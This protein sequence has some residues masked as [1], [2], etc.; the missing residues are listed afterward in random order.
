VGAFLL[1]VNT[2]YSD[3]WSP[4]NYIDTG[5]YF[6]VTSVFEHHCAGVYGTGGTD[7]SCN[8]AVYHRL[9]GSSFASSY[10]IKAPGFVEGESFLGAG[11]IVNSG[12]ADA[13]NSKY[14]LLNNNSAVQTAAVAP[15]VHTV[16]MVLRRPTSSAWDGPVEIVFHGSSGFATVSTG[17]GLG[18]TASSW[19]WVNSPQFTVSGTGFPLTITNRGGGTIQ[20]DALW[21][22]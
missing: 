15:G 12:L 5:T 2:R 6:R 16:S 13:S 22:R 17:T 9:P 8:A 20:F 21:I 1:S 19:S 14:L 11:S 3:F 18:V 10:S 4:Y 7:N